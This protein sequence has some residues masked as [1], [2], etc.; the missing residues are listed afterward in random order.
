M[1]DLATAEF[2]LVRT[3]QPY[4]IRTSTRL[5]WRSNVDARVTD[6]ILTHLI[7]QSG[8]GLDFDV[9]FDAATLDQIINAMAHAQCHWESTGM[10]ADLLHG[11]RLFTV[12]AKR[13]AHAAKDNPHARFALRIR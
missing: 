1:S 9:S 4:G 6:V 8:L 3:D 7:E 11:V 5:A 10:N 12:C 13:M 2:L